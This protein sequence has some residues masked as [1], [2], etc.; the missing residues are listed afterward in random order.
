MIS[1]IGRSAALLVGASAFAA[2]LAS[3][4]AAASPQQATLQGFVGTWDCVTRTADN[5]TYKETDTDTMFGNWLR[6]EGALP[7]QNGAPAGSSTTFAGYD[8]QHRRWVITGVG[9]DNSYF[10]AISN[11]T[12]WDGSKW[13]D[14]YPDDHGTAL[15]HGPSGGRYTL[16][17][18]G[19]DGH[20]KMTTSH[21]VCTKR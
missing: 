2:M 13:T 17:S 20:G 8:S 16:V 18:T 14:V 1:W 4:S 6:I 5:K 21:A 9:T 11:S 3:A 12:A 10:T 15:V 7:A 19:P